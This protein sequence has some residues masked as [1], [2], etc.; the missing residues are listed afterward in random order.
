MP[1]A[2]F[3]LFPFS[4]PKSIFLQLRAIKSIST[5][6][7]FNL[8]LACVAKCILHLDEKEPRTAEAT[9]H[10]LAVVS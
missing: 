9:D 8:V 1:V 4:T 7:T 5:K 6:E 2:V 10:R 3:N